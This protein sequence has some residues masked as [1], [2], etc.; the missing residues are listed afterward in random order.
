MA[1]TKDMEHMSGLV[2]T[3]T[4]ANGRR[5]SNTGMEYS[6]GL[7]DMYTMDNGNKIRKI[8]GYPR[9]KDGDKYYGQ[10]KNDLKD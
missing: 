7:K 5:M 6:D 9:W 1:T 10:Y 8:D 4:S 3:D 2:E